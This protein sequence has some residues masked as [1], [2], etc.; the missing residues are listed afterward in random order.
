VAWLASGAGPVASARAVAPDAVRSLPLP[1]ALTVVG[2]GLVVLGLEIWGASWLASAR[3]RERAA[4]RPSRVAQLALRSGRF[5]LALGARAALPGGT[6][7]AVG[8]GALLLGAVAVVLAVVGS[9]VFSANIDRLVDTPARFGWPFDAAAVIG[10]GYGGADEEALARTLDRDD[11]DRWGLA[12]LPGEVTV[13]GESLPALADQRGFDAF[14]VPVVDGRLPTGDDEIALGARSAERLDLGIGDRVTLGTTYGE[15]D[16]EV[17]G[18]VVLP[19]IGPFQS[20]R[21]GLGTGALL[22]RPLLQRIVGDAEK[23]AGVP[24]GTLG[25]TLGSFLVLDLAAGTDPAAVLADLEDES[26][27]WDVNGSP[28][29]PLADAVRP[30]EIADVA[31]MRS[32]P[33]LVAGLLATSMAVALAL[34]IAL[35]T[36]ARRRQLAIVRALGATPGQLRSTVRWHAVTVVAVGLAGGIVLGISLGSL[37]WRAFSDG[38][39]VLPSVAVPWRLLAAGSLLAVLVALAAAEPPARLAPSRAASHPLRQE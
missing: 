2:V 28:V 8:T 9:V 25:A 24:A 34:A 20:E 13:R 33:A 1:V 3:Q 23:S 26:A 4:P 19:S 17:T 12:A 5:P 37:T 21:A 6:G 29:F 15:R 27:T 32:A 36:R 10:F 39:G 31:A 18:L 7:T 38:L 35:A 30:P 16:A 22:S 11:V 14:A